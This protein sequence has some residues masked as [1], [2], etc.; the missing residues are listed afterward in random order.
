MKK[1]ITLFV[2]IEL[3]IILAVIAIFLIDRWQVSTSPNLTERIEFAPAVKLEYAKE[4][5][6]VIDTSHG[7]CNIRD[8]VA[9]LCNNIVPVDSSMEEEWVYRFTF[10]PDEICPKDDEIVILFGE[11]SM[12]IDEMRYILKD[13]TPYS[14]ILEWV[15]VTYDY[16]S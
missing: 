2:A 3:V 8:Q 9:A 4:A 10:Y 12:S 5:E 6:P 16:F 14:S 11:T 15:E 1:V 7:L 13:D